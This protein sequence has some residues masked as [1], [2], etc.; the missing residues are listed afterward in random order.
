MSVTS[1]KLLQAAAEVVGGEELLAE[2]LGI[3]PQFLSA[4]LQDR[5]QLP[6][7]LLLRA[8]DIILSDRHSRLGLQETGVNPQPN[9]LG[10]S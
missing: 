10:D 2:R 1:V 4:Y 8:V 6:D 7:W 9:R 5:R 3:R